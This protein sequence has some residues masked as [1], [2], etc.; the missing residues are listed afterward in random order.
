MDEPA[1]LPALVPGLTAEE[2]GATTRDLVAVTALVEEGGTLAATETDLET[3]WRWGLP[4]ALFHFSLRD[5]EFM[6]IEAVEEL[7]MA[8]I[9]TAPQPQFHDRNHREA[10]LPLPP[11][12]D[13]NELLALMAKRRTIR[14][15]APSAIGLAALSDCS[16]PGWASS[17]KPATASARCPWR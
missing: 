8:R 13:G 6:A 4:A 2:L 5:R 14:E 17:A 7:Q 1:D 15:A 11:A 9:A 12:T 10:A 3:S 16:S